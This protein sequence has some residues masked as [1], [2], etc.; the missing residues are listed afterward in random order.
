MPNTPSLQEF[1]DLAH[2]LDGAEALIERLGEV[3]DHALPLIRR[4]AEEAPQEW[5]NLEASA[6]DA[7]RILRGP[8]E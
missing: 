3:V 1:S 8:R 5:S 7:L 2:R 6:H 4:A